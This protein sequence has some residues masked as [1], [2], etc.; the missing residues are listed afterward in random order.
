MQLLVS[1]TSPFARKTRM[2]AIE[3]KFGEDELEIVDA[4]PWINFTGVVD[5]NPLNKVPVLILPGRDR[6]GRFESHRRLSGFRPPAASRPPRSRGA[7]ARQIARSARR[8]SDRRRRRR[9]YGRARRRRNA[10]I[11]KMARVA[12]RKSPP[13]V[14]AFRRDFAPR[15]F[16][17]WRRLVARRHRPRLRLGFADFR[18]PELQWRRDCKRLVE[19]LEKMK[20]RE[21]F[22]QTAPP[23]PPSSPPDAKAA[24]K[25]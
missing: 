7:G 13:R 16:F 23:P 6:F 25:G 14:F 10:D 3:K 12:T 5:H 24:T 4:N 8:R 22:A 19:W 21:S 15:R 9:D 17:A 18:A 20:T 1:P 2:M 11:R